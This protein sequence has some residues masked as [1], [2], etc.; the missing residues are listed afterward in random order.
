MIW[1]VFFLMGGGM[2]L[3][4]FVIGL[5]EVIFIILDV[6]C[7]KLEINVSYFCFVF[8]DLIGMC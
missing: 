3:G 2:L 5:C 7:L 4:N 6:D 8:V 1:I